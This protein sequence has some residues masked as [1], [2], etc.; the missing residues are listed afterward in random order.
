M[1]VIHLACVAPPEIGGIG[2]VAYDEVVG[3]CGRGKRAVLISSSSKARG[4]SNI[5]HVIHLPTWLRVGNASI[6][7]GLFSVLKRADVIHLH[8]PWYGVAEWLLLF[9]PRIPVVVTFH[10]DATAT[11]WRGKIFELHRKYIQTR[12]LRRAAKVLVSSRDY[13]EQSSLRHVLKDLGDKL[14]ELPFGIDTDFFSPPKEGASTFGRA[15]S[16]LFVGGL[17]R[18]HDFK[19]LPVLLEAMQMLPSDVTLDI[20]GDGSE[21]GFYEKRV[22]ETGLSSRVHF[23]GRVEREAL[24]DVYRSSTVLAFPSTSAAEAFG[25]VAVE[26][27]ACGTPVV[28]SRLPGVRTVVRDEETG[29]L[30]EPG[31]VSALANALKRV[32]TN[33]VLRATLSQ[34][35]R[36]HALDVYSA[37]HHLDR[38]LEIYQE[39][40]S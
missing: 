14:V 12:L 38:L 28:A 17:D 5:D 30:V 36:A 24:R 34:A 29:L 32:L 39:L 19:G 23:H 37:S 10:M 9:R 1:R 21:R 18:A 27:Q 6:P 35:A 25:L 33:E 40:C 26:A 11:D 31:S 3:L 15:K 7:C 20:V 13:A 2:Q 22:D 4:S 16:I 8:Y